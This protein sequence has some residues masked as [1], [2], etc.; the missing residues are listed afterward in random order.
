MTKKPSPKPIGKS[1]AEIIRAEIDKRTGGSGQSKQE[2]ETAPP[3]PREFIHRW[4][5]THGKKPQD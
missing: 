4:M 3:S 1:R 2:E 5:A